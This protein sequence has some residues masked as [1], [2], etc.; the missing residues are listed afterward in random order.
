VGK[1]IG[2]VRTFALENY[3]V[4]FAKLFGDAE[5][6]GLVLVVVE[7]EK[8]LVDGH[9]EGVFFGHDRGETQGSLLGGIR[10]SK[11]ELLC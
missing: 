10:L 7:R 1:R 11:R 2:K 8:A 5:G 4:V 3:V 6:V 9:A